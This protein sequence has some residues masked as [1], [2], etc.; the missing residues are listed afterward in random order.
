[1]FADRHPQVYR[2]SRAGLP[3]ALVGALVAGCT[4]HTSADHR[5]LTASP[6]ECDGITNAVMSWSA[7]KVSLT[8]PAAPALD[9]T[10]M[11]R[12]MTKM[13][14]VYKVNLPLA[15]AKVTARVAAANRNSPIVQTAAFAGATAFQGAL[16]KVGVHNAAINQGVEVDN[17]MGRNIGEVWVTVASERC[18]S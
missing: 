9:P 1:M 11:G 8:D 16:E 14:G 17:D 13:A 10:A 2:L 7:Y 15:G 3:L 12:A 4:S 5:K 6:S 18:Q